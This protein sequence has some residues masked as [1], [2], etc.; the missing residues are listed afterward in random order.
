MNRLASAEK[1]W[2][3]SG[4]IASR[5][6]LRFFPDRLHPAITHLLKSEAKTEGSDHTSAEAGKK[7]ESVSASE[8]DDA[9]ADGVP[10][11]WPNGRVYA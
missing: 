4:A 5:P 8:P 9:D 3:G 7:P 2:T 11:I 10:P 1:A 6:L